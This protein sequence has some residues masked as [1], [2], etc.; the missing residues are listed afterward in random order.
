MGRSFI[1]LSVIILGNSSVT[2][3]GNSVRSQ[4][5]ELSGLKT[6]AEKSGFTATSLHREVLEFQQ[7]LA[8]AASHVSNREIGRTVNG[9]EMLATIV[10]QPAYTFGSR[11]DDRLVVLLLGNIHSGECAGKEG[12]LLLLRDLAGNANHPWLKNLVIVCLPNYNADGNDRIGRNEIHRPGQVGPAKGMGLRENAQQLDLNRDFMKIESPEARALVRLID[13]INPHLFID[14]H[15]TNGS[16]H[17]YQLTYDIPHNPTAPKSLRDFMRDQMM[18]VVTRKLEEKDVSTFYYGN[19]SRDQTRWTTYGHEPRYST[20]YVGLRGRLSILSEAYS[21]I[22]YK[23]RIFASKEFVTEC[24][25]FVHEHPQQVARLLSSIEADSNKQTGEL[26]LAAE[27]QPFEKKFELKGYDGNSDRP[28]DVKVDFYG[29]YVSTRE[30]EIPHGYVLSAKEGRVVDRLLMHGIKVH[31]VT[32]NMSAKLGQFKIEEIK[33]AR[34]FQKHQMVSLTGNWQTV[35]KIIRVGDYFV[36]AKQPLGRLA[37]YLLEPESNDGLTTWNFF[38]SAIDTSPFFPVYTLAEDPATL[39]TQPISQV[40][41]ARQLTI[42]E[43]YGLKGKINFGGNANPEIAWISSSH[44]RTLWNGRPLSVDAAT[45]NF[46]RLPFISNRLIE[47][48][49]VKSAKLTPELAAKVALGKRIEVKDAIVIEAE[50]DLFWISINDQRAVRLTNDSGKEELVTPSPDRLKIGFVK[51]NNLYRIDLQTGKITQVTDSGND[52]ILNGKLDWVYQEEL[53]GRGNYK[54]F[55]WSSDSQSLAYLTLDQSR[56]KRYQVTDHIPVRQS[57][58][59]YPYPKA[60]DPNPQVSISVDGQTLDL[61]S[62]G[63][64]EPLISQVCWSPTGKVFFQ[65]QN[66]IQNQMMLVSWKPGEAAQ[67]IVT[68]SVDKGWID[69]PG[70]PIWVTGQNGFV[71]FT[72]R[73]GRRQIATYDANGKILESPAGM[74]HPA[75]SKIEVRELVGVTRD[76][77]YFLAANPNDVTRTQ[78]YRLAHDGKSTLITNPQLNHTV[79]ANPALTYFLDYESSIGMPTRV[80]LREM[81][82]SFVRYVEPNLVDYLDYYELAQ[83]RFQKVPTRDGEQLDSM[84]ILPPDFDPSRKYPVLMHV[85]AGPQAPRVRNRWS[86]TSYLWHQ[87]L[88]QKG[89][90]VWMCDNRSATHRGMDLTYPIYGDLGRRELRDIEDSLSWLKKHSWVDDKRIGIWGWSYGGY[91]TSYAM[92]HSKSFKLGIAG[93]PVT[94]WRNYDSIYT[95]RYMGLPSENQ[96]GYDDSSVVR[97]AGN[98]HGQLMIIHGTQDDNVHISNTFQLINALQNHG[99]QFRLMIYPKNRHGIRVPSQTQHLRQLMTDFIVENL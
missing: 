97:A 4:Q 18:P 56:V 90:V 81:D 39:S 10:A 26:S 51:A 33:R 73:T 98:L 6:V 16:R 37:A 70:N 34:E 31:R 60:G 35:Q 42:E 57:H 84:L 12:L 80:A 92:T 29:K 48:K 24:V 19:F 1:F 15:T 69:S 71:W 53:Y 9:R 25:Q 83:P 63:L 44:Y 82:G 13:D 32:K 86:G 52:N 43:L 96:Q 40:E 72:H 85:Y 11:T 36:S 58:E 47:S 99:K 62:F 77:V 59:V 88:A 27:V 3:T 28:K 87:M 65:L 20:E 14:C 5:P 23:D 30:K 41:P 54:G 21:Y 45:G 38:D 78:L 22:S 93:A 75:T 49:L 66:R 74:T 67:K 17:R 79:K 64:K 55:W 8:Q 91:M 68:E 95:E 94:D 7:Q 50:N 46:E 61:S 76:S 2:W 89:F